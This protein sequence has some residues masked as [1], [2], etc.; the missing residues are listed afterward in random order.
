MDE[1]LEMA[2]ALVG[3]SLT[4]FI[5]TG[6]SKYLTNGEAPSWTELLLECVKKIDEGDK[7]KNLLFKFNIAK[8]CYECIY[9]PTIC[10]QIIELE[11]IKKDKNLRDC[12]C[13]II[14][15]NINPFT[16]D[17]EKIKGLQEFFKD[18]DRLNIITTNYDTLISEYILEDK[19]RVFVEGSPIPTINTA[20][21][22]FHIHGS[23]NNP[24][25]LILTLNDYFKFQQRQNYFSRKFYTLLQENTTVI[26]GYSLGDFNLNN[27]LN[28]VQS[29][30]NPS[31]KHSNIY[32]V[33]RSKVEGTLKDYYHYTFGIQV[34]DECNID[35]F[36]KRLQDKISEAQE[37]V[38]EMGRLKK[39]LYE[40]KTFKDSFLKLHD[41]LFRIL[42]YAQSLGIGV[43]NPKFRRLII[44]LLNKKREFTRE[45]GAWVQYEHLAEWL[46]EIASIIN[47]KGTVLE[48]EYLELVEY[49]FENMSK[50]LKIGYSWEAYKAWLSGFKNIKLDNRKMIGKLIEERFTKS[51]CANNLLAS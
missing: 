41:S 26:L 45:N 37:I 20:Q 28:E 50:S 30:S 49:S 38:N 3:N 8:N 42:M 2:T 39:V 43:N 19:S 5:G 48:E 47:L 15:C 34:I 17:D 31:I 6:F 7:L 1:F 40:G 32:Y 35:D 29:Y 21:N 23:I 14:D 27:I 36:F 25:S 18:H 44:N 24:D 4:L 46:V 33:T 9:E 16:T 11:Y 10:A 13:E 12:V 51:H 22:V